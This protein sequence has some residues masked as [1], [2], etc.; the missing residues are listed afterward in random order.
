M[1]TI[2]WI[3]NLPAPSQPVIPA[4]P[5]QTP[6][7]QVELSRY[8]RAI[9]RHLWKV[10]VASLLCVAAAI[11]ISL[12]IQP[13]FE[14]TAM[15]DV[16]CRVPTAVLGP[17]ATRA[18]AEDVDAFLATQIRL[19]Q[20]DS[21]LR[22]VAERFK[23][24]TPAEDARTDAPVLLPGL[25]VMRPAGTYVILITFRSHDRQLSADVA[26]GVCI[27][28]TGRSEGQDGGVDSGAVTV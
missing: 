23:L 27:E 13:S 4:Y 24:N 9:K 26:N 22:P 14:S 20:S 17:E 25:K 19:I 7:S 16:D 15:V 6:D 8:F 3:P 11:F 5:P 2:R 1:S 21:V 10:G 28:G 12:R 18:G